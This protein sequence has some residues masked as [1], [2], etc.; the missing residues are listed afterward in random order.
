MVDVYIL[1]Y[2]KETSR[3]K[4]LKRNSSEILNVYYRA[5]EIKNDETINLNFRDRM[6][7]Q[8]RRATGPL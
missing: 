3:L 4:R 6:A 2:R 5:N 8:Y 1:I 7:R